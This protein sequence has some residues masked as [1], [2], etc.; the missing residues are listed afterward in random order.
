MNFN[1]IYLKYLLAIFGIVSTV[2]PHVLSFR[3]QR[4]RVRYP[5]TD[6]IVPGVIL[7]LEGMSQCVQVFLAKL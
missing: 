1:M 2:S 3:G 6:W 7:D 5:Q 4:L